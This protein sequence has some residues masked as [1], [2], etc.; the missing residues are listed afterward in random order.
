MFG[1]GSQGAQQYCPAAH[2]CD[3]GKQGATRAYYGELNGIYMGTGDVVS[4]AWWRSYRIELGSFALHLPGSASHQVSYNIS[5]NKL[6]RESLID[7]L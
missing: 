7:C 6:L 1:E 4:Q 2:A 3:D 5:S